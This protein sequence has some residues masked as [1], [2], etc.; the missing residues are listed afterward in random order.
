MFEGGDPASKLRYINLCL[1]IYE[2][3]S[4]GG[5][6]WILEDTVYL[7]NIELQP[8]IPRMDMSVYNDDRKQMGFPF[9]SMVNR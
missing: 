3:E 7:K 4:S 2:C 6:E 8:S 5:S 9:S 1:A